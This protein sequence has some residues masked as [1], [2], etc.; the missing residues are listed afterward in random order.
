MKR[1]HNKIILKA[2]E[3]NC[4]ILVNTAQALGC[5]R[6]QLKKWIDNDPELTEGYNIGKEKFKDL[7]EYQ[8]LKNIREGKE[9]TLIFYAKTR[10][11]DRGFIEKQ[12][13]N[14]TIDAVKIKYIIPSEDQNLLTEDDQKLI[15]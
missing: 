4:S 12:D 11:R 14:M 7:V 13:M 6:Q 2:L 1:P 9:A 15:R 8:M 5:G 10:M 3:D